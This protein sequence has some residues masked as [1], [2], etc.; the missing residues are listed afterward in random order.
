[1]QS[2]YDSCA[3]LA[4]WSVA[5]MLQPAEVAQS[6]HGVQG[7]VRVPTILSDCW[8]RFS[9]SGRESKPVAPTPS[10]ARKIQCWEKQKGAQ[11]LTVSVHCS[12]DKKEQ[13]MWSI[14][15]NHRA[16]RN[17]S[18]ITGILQQ[19]RY[20]QYV[21]FFNPK[22]LLHWS[23]YSYFFSGVYLKDKFKLLPLYKTLILLILK[24]CTG[25]LVANTKDIQ[26]L[27]FKTWKTKN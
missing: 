17:S 26:Y 4:S 23:G 24:I 13:A 19:D 10:S 16:S 18:R 21:C 27:H 8:L 5:Q 1:M 11:W 15:S 3:N 25:V 22:P 6:C 20:V 12:L 14:G 2:S 7:W 9:V